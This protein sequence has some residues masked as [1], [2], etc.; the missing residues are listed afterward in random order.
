AH[1]SLHLDGQVPAIVDQLPPQL[2]ALPPT[3]VRRVGAKD[4]Q[5]AQDQTQVSVELSPA[6]AGLFTQPP[7][8]KDHHTR[9]ED[10]ARGAALPKPAKN[11]RA[12][13]RSQDR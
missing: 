5:R 13:K 10:R 6:T 7:V 2:A 11:R 4:E 12:V 8:A 9:G 1:A 3:V